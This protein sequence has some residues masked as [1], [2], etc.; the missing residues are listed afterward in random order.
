MSRR[1]SPPLLLQL[2]KVRHSFGSRP[3]LRGIYADVPAGEALV[4]TGP[5]GSGKSTLLR[6]IAGLL[7]PDSGFVRLREGG[8][9][10]SLAER[11]RALGMV[12]PDLRLYHELT[13]LENLR[14]FA[15]LRGLELTEADLQE[16]LEQVGLGGRG[17]D[18]VGGFS[19]GMRVRLKYAQAMLHEPPLLLLDEPTANLD[20]QGREFVEAVIERQRQRG[21]LIL[22][23]NDPR[24]TEHGQQVLSLGD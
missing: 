16:R 6:I 21:I 8:R 19:S 18:L 11:R 9:E 1:E 10:L 4:V 22:A 12:A 13:A 3:V 5:N 2:E 24:E 20:V 17:S 15:L 23:T 7:R 14:F